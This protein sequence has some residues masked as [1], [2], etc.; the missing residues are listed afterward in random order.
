MIKTWRNER[1][2]RLFDQGHPA[3][4]KEKSNE[5]MKI[6]KAIVRAF[7]G[8]DIETALSRLDVLNAAISLDDIPPLKSI[9]LHKLKG[10]RKGG[11]AISI[12]GPWR[13]CFLF[14]NNDAYDVEV[15]DYHKG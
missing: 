1:S 15:T 14:R 12:N 6:R 7:P 10:G 11:W 4:G 5:A 3:S 2:R 13:V 9:S 8:M